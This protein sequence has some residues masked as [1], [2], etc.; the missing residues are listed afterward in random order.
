MTSRRLF[1][2]L[3]AALF[4]VITHASGANAQAA[5]ANISEQADLRWDVKLVIA[6][7]VHRMRGQDDESLYWPARFAQGA[8]KSFPYSDFRYEG[9]SLDAV[10]ILGV[11]PDA[12]DPESLF[13][14]ALLTFRDAL[15]RAASTT[16][17]A[18]YRVSGGNLEIT[19]AAVA[20]VAPERPRTLTFIVPAERMPSHIFDA[21]PDELLAHVASNSVSA[22]G[23]HSPDT[24]DYFVFTWFLNRLPTGAKIDLRISADPDGVIGDRGNTTEFNDRGFR[25]L[26]LR[27]KFALNRSPEFFFK[28]LYAP[29]GAT[30]GEQPITVVSRVSS[31]V[32]GPVAAAPPP[33]PVVAAPLIPRKSD[34]AGGTAEAKP[35]NTFQ[36]L[37]KR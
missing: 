27:G 33:P 23:E 22:K 5:N 21:S 36:N 3:I 1:T 7:A 25:V 20:T 10:A 29:Q 24:R 11:T 4:V 12:L 17:T 18:R 9:Y 31:H 2:A 19:Q 37:L 26:V 28:V 30:D 6:A 15:G 8:D 14:T 13:L 34:D 35:A 32:G 16:L